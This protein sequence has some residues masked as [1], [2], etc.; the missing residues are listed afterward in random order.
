MTSCVLSQN[1]WRASHDILMSLTPD[2]SF[3]AVSAIYKRK[4]YPEN[5]IDWVIQ[6]TG[7]KPGDTVADIGA[8]NGTLGLEFAARGFKVICID[9]SEGMLAKIVQTPGVETC[10]GTSHATTLPNNTVDLVIAGNAAHW[11]KD[12]QTA[13]EFG[14]ILKPGKK[15]V[16]FTMSPSLNDPFIK[17][18][19][20]HMSGSIHTY[21]NRPAFVFHEHDRIKKTAEKF[22]EN[23]K[24]YSTN[25]DVNSTPTDIISYLDTTHTLS[26]VFRES[27]D[28][29]KKLLELAA[30]GVDKNTITYECEAYLGDAKGIYQSRTPD[31]VRR[32]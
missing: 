16:F 3:E 4:P 6:E 19:H 9:P 2:R 28:T 20:E 7:I 17:K 23:M 10:L 18:L 15:A 22:L 1:G 24:H 21:K 26:Q 13:E 30:A 11:F 5:C 25:F 31:A 14:R 12:D 27:P 29:R 32:V 8:G